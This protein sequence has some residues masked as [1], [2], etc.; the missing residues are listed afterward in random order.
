MSKHAKMMD[1]AWVANQLTIT[2]DL[3]EAAIIGYQYMPA[4]GREW[5]SGGQDETTR[6]HCEIVRTAIAK[7]KGES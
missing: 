2:A 7:A 6:A 1:T 3:L 5:E 4:H